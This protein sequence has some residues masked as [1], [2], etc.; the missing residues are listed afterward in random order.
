MEDTLLIFFTFNDKHRDSFAVPFSVSLSVCL[1]PLPFFHILLQQPFTLSSPNKPLRLDLF[2]V[3]H[4]GTGLP[5]ILHPFAPCI[6]TPPM[7]VLTSDSQSTAERRNIW[8][9]T[10]YV[11]IICDV[12]PGASDCLG[13]R[14][15]G[16]HGELP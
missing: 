2:L 1:P 10:Q 15:L 12:P 16:E 14:G 4:C 8:P 11:F 3:V 9:F 5:K 6:L 13:S 7:C